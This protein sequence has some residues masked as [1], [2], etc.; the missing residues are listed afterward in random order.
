MSIQRI[1]TELLKEIKELK[2]ELVVLKMENAFLLFVNEESYSKFK[3]LEEKHDISIKLARAQDALLGKIKQRLEG[4]V[5]LEEM[6]N[7]F[8][9]T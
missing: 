7:I 6:A 3:A 1:N 2:A 8:L 5:D 9:E 4:M